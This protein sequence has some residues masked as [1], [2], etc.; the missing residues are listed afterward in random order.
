MTKNDLNSKEW[1]EKIAQNSRK[2]YLKNTLKN[3]SS[4][5]IVLGV[6]LMLVTARFSDHNAIVDRWA[7]E[8]VDMFASAIIIE[9]S[10]IYWEL[11]DSF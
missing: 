6:G 3:V 1:D 11:E 4:T 5:L 2:K 10:S 7:E 9:D 8:Y